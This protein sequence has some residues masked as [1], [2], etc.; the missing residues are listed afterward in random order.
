[1]T[2]TACFM[3]IVPG[4]FT[5]LPCNCDAKMG[6]KHGLDCAKF[7]N[8]FKD[9]PTIE[10]YV[11]PPF[12]PMTPQSQ[13]EQCGRCWQNHAPGFVCA[14]ACHETDEERDIRLYPDNGDDLDAPQNT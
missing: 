2:A 10:P 8:P 12:K 11:R 9:T 14:C 5:P 1:M 4:G 3:Q 13:G 6:D 7:H